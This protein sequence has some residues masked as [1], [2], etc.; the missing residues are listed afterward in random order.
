VDLLRIR[1]GAALPGDIVAELAGTLDRLARSSRHLHTDGTAYRYELGESLARTAAEQARAL[2][3]RPDQLWPEVVQRLRGEHGRAPSGFAAVEVAPRTSAEVPDTPELRL[4][5]THPALGHERGHERGLDG[6]LAGGLDDGLD[7][8]LA[9][10]D[11]ASPAARFAA[12]V[13]RHRGAQPR[14]YRNRLVFLAADLRDLDDLAAAAA[15]FLAWDHVYRRRSPL[16]LSAAQTELV[17]QRRTRADEVL[18]GRIR[19]G[20]AWV[21]VPEQ[22][23]P[24]APLQL[25]AERLGGATG[26]PADRVAAHLHATGLLARTASPARLRAD[27]DGSLRTLWQGGHVSVGT[28]WEHYARHAHLTRLP[29]RQALLDAVAAVL[30]SSPWCD[31][32]FALAE[33]HDPDT[34][35]YRGLVLPG[36]GLPGTGLPGTGTPGTGT[37]FGEIGDGTLLVAPDAALAQA[38]VVRVAGVATA[39]APSVDAE[40]PTST[41]S[42][43]A[44]ARPGAAVATTRFD[45]AYRAGRPGGA[46]PA[47]AARDLAA[48]GREIVHLLATTNGADVEVTVLIRAT[49]HGG[50]PETTV[51]AVQENA[52]TL[53]VECDFVALADTAGEF[54]QGGVTAR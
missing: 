52:R 15:D 44:P 41:G 6:T 12:D 38:D 35:R 14:V 20:Y 4:V 54:P 31:E 13:V 23:D 26:P 22:P 16:G 2:R 42:V 9:G 17:S 10:M 45:G 25:A 18:A 27:L 19:R 21:L 3:A 39:A 43:A 50:F 8:G 49:S 34:G 48:I 53:H 33:G 47:R 36:T 51:R 32:G 5:L 40:D 1:L 7:G 37:Q 11:G 29:D 46:D 30:G 24:T 28:L